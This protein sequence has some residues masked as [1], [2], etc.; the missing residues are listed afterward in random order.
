[1]SERQQPPGLHLLPS[2]PILVV[3]NT[4]T[5][6]QGKV[7]FVPLQGNVIR[8]YSCGPTVYDAAHMGHARNY[9]TFDI[10]RRILSRLF[11]V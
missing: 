2:R 4:L 5:K 9:V 6:E 1:M 11:Q 10:I 3:K 8:W 7:P